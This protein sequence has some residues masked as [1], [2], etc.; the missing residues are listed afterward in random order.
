MRDALLGRAL[1]LGIDVD[2]AYLP[3]AELSLD[4]VV[5]TGQSGEVA[6]G[7]Y[8]RLTFYRLL[9]QAG[10]PRI[11][12]HAA[13]HTTATLLKNLRVPV[14]DVQAILGH[15]SAIT[16]QQIYQ[17]G[18]ETIQRDAASSIANII[19]RPS[20]LVYNP[21]RGN[22][23]QKLLSNPENQSAKHKARPNHIYK[24]LVA[25]IGLEPTTQGSSGLCSTN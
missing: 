13:R 21:A 7:R 16:T 20:S 6:D 24:Y 15:A 2:N 23:C 12:P 4:G 18:D 11:T 1:N 3:E 5:V 19:S 25:P 9:K 8:F 22:C 17:H 10:L 14:R